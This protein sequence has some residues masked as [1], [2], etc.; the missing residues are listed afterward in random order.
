MIDFLTEALRLLI[1]LFK[2]NMC[3]SSAVCAMLNVVVNACVYVYLCVFS[4]WSACTKACF[5]LTFTFSSTSLR[6]PFSPPEL[7]YARPKI[8]SGFRI[9][10]PP[11][12]ALTIAQAN[13]CPSGLP[14]CSWQQNLCHFSSSLSFMCVILLPLNSHRP[15]AQGKHTS[16]LQYKPAVHLWRFLLK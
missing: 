9:V 7:L 16:S 2:A 13:C 6:F 12:S 5:V 8:L 1:C 14:A 15:P 4:E 3:K 11:F 10:P